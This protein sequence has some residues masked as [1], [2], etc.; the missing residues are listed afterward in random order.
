M[1]DKKARQNAVFDEFCRAIFVTLF[2]TLRSFAGAKKSLQT[3][4]IGLFD[5]WKRTLFTYK[6]ARITAL[7]DN[8]RH[9]KRKNGVTNVTNLKVEKCG[10]GHLHRNCSGKQ[11]K[12]FKSHGFEGFLW[13]RRKDSNPHKR[14]QSP[15]CYLYTTPLKQ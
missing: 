15:V 1:R 3:Q 7:F 12:S 11:E 2:V 6:T 8:N 14:S 5:I 10:F 9:E 13:Q 4:I